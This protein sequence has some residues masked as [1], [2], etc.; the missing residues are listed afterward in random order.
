MSKNAAIGNA[1]ENNVGSPQAYL[2]ID[3]GALVRNYQHLATLG[4]GANCSA[5]VKAD[6]Y[7]LGAHVVAPTLWKAGCRTF[8]VA[9]TPEG[10]SMRFILPQEAEIYVLSPYLKTDAEALATFSLIPVLNDP[11]DLEDWRHYAHQREETLA[12]A[13]HV[14]TGMSRLGYAVDQFK[15]M[16]LNKELEGVELKSLLSHLACADT[17]HHSL[18]ARQLA[19]F[20]ELKLVCQSQNIDCQFSLANSAG[21]LLGDDYHFDLLRPG[22]ALYG[23]NPTDNGRSVFEPVVKLD[24]RILQI[25]TASPNETVGYGAAYRCLDEMRIAIVG[26]GYADGY[27]RSLGN[28]SMVGFK[29]HRLAVIGRI[30]MDLIAVDIS[31][32]PE[33]QI[34][35]GDRVEIIGKS[36]TLNEVAR[37]AGTIDY[38]ILC[39]LGNRLARRYIEP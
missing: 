8:F 24:A 15:A 5:V 4:K 1:K 30:S 18:N 16:D 29:G 34:H 28:R 38:E 13:I 21:I 31:E 17:P 26:L 32:V 12:C 22:I 11:A 6:A 39:G 10:V 37:S 27:P 19:A 33:D 2:S 35:P 20:L 9:H 7:G 36:M 3:L 25:R 14:D 23:G